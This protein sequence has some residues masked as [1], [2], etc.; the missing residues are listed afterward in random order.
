MTADLH[1]PFK[2]CRAFY[3]VFTGEKSIRTEFRA[4]FKHRALKFS[5]LFQSG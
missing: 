3:H 5:L 1:I 2:C 4:Y